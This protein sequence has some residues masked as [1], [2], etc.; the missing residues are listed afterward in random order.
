LIADK[1]RRSEVRKIII[2]VIAVAMLAVPTVANA[3][4]SY[5]ATNDGVITG[6]IGKGDV[7]PVLGWNENMVQNTPVNFTTT[8][9][10][11]T[12]KS[13]QCTNG[14][15]RHNLWISNFKQGLAKETVLKSNGKIDGWKLT[16]LGGL[17]LIDSQRDVGYKWLD[18][19]GAGSVNYM[20]MLTDQRHAF[21]DDLFVNDMLLPETPVVV[22]V[23]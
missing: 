5:D 17:T 9:T 1:Y 18:C 22:S 11:T 15:V 4:V 8:F 23:A 2:G 3:A 14:E 7:Q 12:D 19:A 10:V 6:Y 21:G 20:T 13:W 16:G